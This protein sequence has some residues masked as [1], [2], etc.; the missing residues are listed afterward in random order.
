MIEMHQ[1]FRIT[2][3]F[4]INKNGACFLN[5]KRIELLKL[6]HARGS[7]LAASKEMRMSYQQAWTMIK[8]INST[9]S[10]PVVTRQRGGTNGGG[11]IVTNFG[12]RLIE[13]YDEIR[14]E[15][16]QFLS[17]LEENLGICFF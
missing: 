12:L 15:Y 1:P 6:V 8:D 7:I 14:T 17:G 2:S 5:S 11:A 3:N 10:L 9:A 4:E 16:K 13:R